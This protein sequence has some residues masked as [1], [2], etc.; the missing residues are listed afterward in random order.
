MYLIVPAG[1]HHSP[2][3]TGLGFKSF[4]ARHHAYRELRMTPERITKE[5]LSVR[6]VVRRTDAGASPFRWEVYLEQGAAPLYVS[7][8]R[9]SSMEA[10]YNAGQARLKEF[11]P[12]R[13]VPPQVHRESPGPIAPDRLG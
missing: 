4:T 5:A 12:K 1:C 9:F 8:D 10:A 11:I 7:P 3:G 13:S 6:V 2:F